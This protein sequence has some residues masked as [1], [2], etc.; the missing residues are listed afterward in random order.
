MVCPC[1]MGLK[2]SLMGMME[3]RLGGGWSFQIPIGTAILY[4]HF[5]TVYLYQVLNL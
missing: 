4:V 1:A 5:L 3:E 2:Q